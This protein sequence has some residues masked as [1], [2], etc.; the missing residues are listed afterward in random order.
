M[1]TSLIEKAKYLRENS[2]KAEDLLWKR[3]RNRQLGIKF[4][5]QTPLIIGECKFIADFCCIKEKLIIEIDGSIHNNPE[6]KEYDENREKALKEYG[7]TILRFRN[8][9]ILNSIKTVLEKIKKYSKSL[10]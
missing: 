3:I 9:E 4:R 5:R 1:K 2:T 10:F 7:Y 6:N 8:E